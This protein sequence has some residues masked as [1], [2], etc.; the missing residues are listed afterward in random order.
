M[1]SPDPSANTGDIRHGMST[2]DTCNALRFDLFL[3]LARHS[4]AWPLTSIRPTP[5]LRGY[6]RIKAVGFPQPEQNLPTA[7]NLFVKRTP[8]CPHPT[9]HPLKSKSG[10]RFHP[11]TCQQL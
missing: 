6:P 10:S 7:I 11:G 4:F 3:I 8:S 9:L 1:A 5:A 2:D